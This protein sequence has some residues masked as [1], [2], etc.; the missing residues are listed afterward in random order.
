MTKPLIY[1][2]YDYY[3][4][5]T[6][7]SWVRILQETFPEA[8]L[9]DPGQPLAE[10]DLNED[11]LADIPCVASPE[12]LQLL[13]FPPHLAASVREEGVPAALAEAQNMAKGGYVASILAVNHY[14]LVR[15]SLVVV[16]GDAAFSS[17]PS[18]DLVL[19]TQL[20]IPTV[21]VCNR[22]IQPPWLLAYADVSVTTPKLVKLVATVLRFQQE[23]QKEEE[24][25]E[26]DTPPEQTPEP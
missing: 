20:G 10:Q 24:S 18:V 26:L 5:E 15:S 12:V 1:A 21:L 8:I 11:T 25:E 6:Q 19:A 4:S 22:T 16:D 14:L 2:A 9:Y 13:R 23:P 3:E 7:P 17:G